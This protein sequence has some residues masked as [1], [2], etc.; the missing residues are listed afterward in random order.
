MTRRSA[1]ASVSGDENQYGPR[2]TPGPLLSCVMSLH[3]F[4]AVAGWVVGWTINT[5]RARWSS[6]YVVADRNPL[7]RPNPPG[8]STTTDGEKP[9]DVPPLPLSFRPSTSLLAHAHFATANHNRTFCARDRS[10][11]VVSHPALAP[12]RFPG[13]FAVCLCLSFSSCNPMPSS[14]VRYAATN[15]TTAQVSIFHSPVHDGRP[16]LDPRPQINL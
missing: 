11:V 15:V 2:C 10:T 4:K 12:C 13:F 5:G 1:V 14:R 6:C 9:G 16:T 7:P 8:K 3:P